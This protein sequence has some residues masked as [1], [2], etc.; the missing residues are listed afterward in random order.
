MNSAGKIWAIIWKD[1]ISEFRSKE[2]I[3]SMCLFAFQVLI[4]FSFAFESG[5]RSLEDLIPG[6]LWV[7]FIFSGLMGLGRSF[8]AERDGGTLPGL[9]LCPLSRWEIYLAKMI[10]TFIFMVIME[11]LTLI[12]LTILYNQNLLPFLLPLGVIIF[13]GTLGFSAI[14]TIF[15]AMSAT[16]KARQVILSILV[17]PISV[18]LIIASVK[19]TG[20]ILDGSAI[21]AVSSWLKIL[22]AFDLVFLL[23][24]Y[25]TF[26]FIMEE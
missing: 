10:G 11:V 19:A 3:F 21:Q 20:T 22:V 16:T 2:M 15:S 17:F 1:L 24:A 4:V 6:I 18:P 26:E 8:G 13:L 5:F 7:A 14:G 12:V 23:L 25:L 9:L